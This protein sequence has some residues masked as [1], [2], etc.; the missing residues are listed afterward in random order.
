MV[1]I[2][3]ECLATD[4]KQELQEQVQSS[5]GGLVEEYFL[6]LGFL[7]KNQSNLSMPLKNLLK[8]C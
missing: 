8:Y 7:L 1:V 2:E 5:S 6:T 3:E 4:I